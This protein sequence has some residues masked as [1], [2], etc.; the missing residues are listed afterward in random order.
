MLVGSIIMV[1]VNAC[2][3]DEDEY[4]LDNQEFITRASSS[5]MFEIAAGQLAV[6][7]GADAGV[8]SYG[9]HMV[10]D[11]GQAAAEMAAL[12]NNKGLTLPTTMLAEHQAKIDTLQSLTGDAFDKK[13]ALMMVASHKQTIDLFDQASHNPG[14]RDNDLRTFATDKLPTLNE[15]LEEAQHLQ[16]SVND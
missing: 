9:Q 13:Y 2:T 6:N 12:V 10:T 3:K 15:H 4:R 14:V 16:A 7:M 1:A 11:H 8:K 5:N